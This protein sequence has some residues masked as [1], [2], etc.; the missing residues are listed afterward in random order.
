[1]LIIHNYN[2]RD[3]NKHVLSILIILR[4]VVPASKDIKIRGIAVDKWLP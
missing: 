1:M 4:V 3:G 2:F